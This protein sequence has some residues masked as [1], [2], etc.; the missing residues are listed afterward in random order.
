[1][2]EYIAVNIT[3]L[4]I[5]ISLIP[6]PDWFLL[7]KY[8]SSSQINQFK[9]VIVFNKID[10][11]EPH[12]KILNQYRS[13]GYKVIN[14]SIL[15]DDTA[16]LLTELSNETSVFIGQSGVGKSSLINKLGNIKKQ[17]IGD[18]SRKT[19]TGKQ[20]TTTSK[21]LSINNNASIID[22]PGVRSYAPYF[23]N[24]NEVL[25]GFIEFGDFEESCR[26]I[27]CSHISE[28][29]CAI[30]KA[31][32]GVGHATKDQIKYMVKLQ[33]PKIRLKSIDSTDALAVAICHANHLRNSMKIQKKMQ[34]TI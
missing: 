29:D 34:Y 3:Q 20:T 22:S 7:D 12:Q 13:I 31:V 1:M 8:L 16:G 28:P 26:F 9:T 11:G 10:L 6:R 5:V 30:K 27:N 23:N 2:K 19:N 21:L 32:A 18:L 14:T 4:V 15:N 24:T 25:K 33:F 17:V